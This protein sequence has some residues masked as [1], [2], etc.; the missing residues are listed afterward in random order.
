[1]AYQVPKSKASIK[2]NRF[3]FEI[4]GKNFDI[5]LMQFLPMSAAEA[6][7]QEKPIT[8]LMLAAGSDEAASAL[9]SLES[10]QLEG[11][12]KAWQEESEVDR[13]ESP[14]S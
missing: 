2:Q 9:R 11:L 10:D 13:G 8:G 14:A 4:D 6:F 3:T 1:M 12:L 7:E 5:P